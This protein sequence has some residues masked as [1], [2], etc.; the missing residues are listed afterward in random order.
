MKGRPV[1]RVVLEWAGACCLT[2]L[3]GAMGLQVVMRYVFNRP[4][5]WPEELAR[6]LFIWATFIGA[7]LVLRD[8]AHLRV[9]YFRGLCSQR[10][11]TALRMMERLLVLGFLL[12]VLVGSLQIYRPMS[13]FRSAAMGIP[14]LAV[15]AA[16]PLTSLLM[17][18][19]TV[20]QLGRLRRTAGER[21]DHGHPGR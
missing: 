8:D 12:S 18:A 15:L 4:L 17:C 14:L 11:S 3:M 2:V 1:D 9:E 13:V 21:G 16:V 19:Y 7:A 6:Y 5:D 10:I 20:M